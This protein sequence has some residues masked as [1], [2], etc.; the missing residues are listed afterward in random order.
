[1]RRHARRMRRAGLQPMV[2]INADDQLPD[3]IVVSIC[4]FLWR[5]RSELAPAYLALALALGGTILHLTHPTWWTY[6]LI[7]TALTASLP[8][9]FGPRIGLTARGESYY[10][11]A[12]VMAAGSWLSAATA[13]GATVR[14]LPQILLIGGLVLAIPWWAHR[15]RRAKVRVSRKLAAWPEIAQTIGLAGSRV[16]SAIV[17]IWG[18]RARLA[19]ARGQTLDD[20]TAKTPAIESALGTHRGAVRVYPTRDELA[21]RFELRV[22]DT[23]PHADAVAWEPPG[24][25]SI[26]QPIPLGLFEDAT[27][28][29]VN[30]LRRHVLIGGVVGSGKSGILNVIIAALAACRDVVIWGVDLKGGMELAPWRPVLGKLATTP[31]QATALFADAVAELDA[32]ARDLAADGARVWNPSPEAPALIV[33]VDEYAELADTAPDAT[34]HADSIGRRGRAPAVNLIAATQRPTQKA[35]GHGAIRSQMDV[36]I[37]L[38]VRERR[39]ADLILGQGAYAAGWHPHTLNAPGKF[40]LSDPEHTTPHRARAPYIDDHTVTATAARTASQRPSLPTR[41]TNTRPA[42]SDEL[43]PSGTLS[44]SVPEAIL[45]TIL[46]NAPEDGIPVAHL[47]QAT[48]MSRPWIYQRLR[49]LADTGRVTQPSRG[50]WRA[51]PETRE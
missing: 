28:V 45:W 37:C 32:R 16:Q 26:T 12:V 4:R 39:D 43:D 42:T 13:L 24:I 25:T 33:V 38:R 2:V 48:G 15:R 35:M 17:D 40:L 14:P 36:R 20:V 22:L 9:P 49:E 44:P 6:I 1:M 10:A 5:Y 34:R 46:N 19:L 27:P 30:L 23:D 29:L 41:G 7:A 31:R 3:L 21:N 47:M 11:V 18:W 8:V 50:R 51:A